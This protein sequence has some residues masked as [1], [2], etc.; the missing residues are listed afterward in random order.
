VV[1]LALLC[2]SIEIGADPV[3]IQASQLESDLRHV[4]VDAQERIITPNNS[5]ADETMCRSGHRDSSLH[6]Q[7]VTSLV[8]F[9]RVYFCV[10]VRGGPQDDH[11]LHKSMRDGI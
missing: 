10:C 6:S 7:P 1:A 3:A 11:R 8:L 2:A 9:Q 5:A 4:H